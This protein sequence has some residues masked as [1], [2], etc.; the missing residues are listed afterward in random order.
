MIKAI[1]YTIMLTMII[2]VC[3]TWNAAR[4]IDVAYQ[5][6]AKLNAP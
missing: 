3:M 4:D 1:L 5:D 6:P 2:I